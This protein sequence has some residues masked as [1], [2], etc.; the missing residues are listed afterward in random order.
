MPTS[1]EV[2]YL[3]TSALVKTVDAEPES[4]ALRHWLG[5]ILTYDHRTMDAAG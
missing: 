1:G 4:E 2:W 3:D 5:A